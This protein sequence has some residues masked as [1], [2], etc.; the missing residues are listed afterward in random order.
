MAYGLNKVILIG[1]LGRDPEIRHTDGGAIVANFPL[2]TTEY[3]KDKNGQRQEQTEWHQIVAWRSQAEY[4]Q[5]YL[6]KGFTLMVEGKIRTRSW[7]D[8]ERVKRYTTE[9]IADSFQ[10]ISSPRRED[11]GQHNDGSVSGQGSHNSS[12]SGQLDDLPF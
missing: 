2:A 12:S 11:S 4:A 1:N 6:K 7:E 10:L 5:K 9:I 3:Y 8:K